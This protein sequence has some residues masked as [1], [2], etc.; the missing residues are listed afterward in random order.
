MNIRVGTGRR[1]LTIAVFVVLSGNLYG[2]RSSPRVP[3]S[4]GGASKEEAKAKLAT[5]RKL[6]DE[7]Y[8]LQAKLSEERTDWKV[9]KEI[10]ESRVSLFQSQVDD[11]KE[12][13]KEEEGNITAADEEREDLMEENEALEAV[14]ILQKNAID[15]HER[16]VREIVPRLPEV[17]TVKIQLLIDRLPEPGKKPEEIKS[18]VSERYQ[19]VLGILNEIN[20]FNSDVHVV[21]ERRET[22]DGTE[23]SVQTMYI[24]LAQAFFVGEGETAGFAGIGHVTPEG[25]VWEERPDLAE[26]VGQLVQMH[27]AELPADF[28][29]VPIQID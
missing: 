14:Q 6:L 1:L 16:R 19:N 21:N 25:W 28:V 17:L 11:L 9:G 10:M 4:G 15:N 22:A 8:D 24:G 13:I 29:D 2:Q 23:V 7:N 26:V 27:S 5:I 20:K 18:S 3:A 12:K